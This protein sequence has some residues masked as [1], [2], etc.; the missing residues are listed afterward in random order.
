VPSEVF[1]ESETVGF[2]VVPHTTPLAVIAYPTS[3]EMFPPL[4]AEV[5]VI[6]LI[7]EVEEILGEVPANVVN[8]NSE[9]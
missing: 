8:D 1:V 5:V 3:D 2:V 9:P 6:E 4:E 7:A